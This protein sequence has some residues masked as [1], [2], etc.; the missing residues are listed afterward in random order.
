[1]TPVKLTG[2]ETPTDSYDAVNKQYFDDNF[3]SLNA[4]LDGLDLGTVGGAQNRSMA[5]SNAFKIKKVV[6]WSDG[7][8]GFEISSNDGIYNG[9]RVIICMAEANY[10]GGSVYTIV[11]STT[12]GVSFEKDINVTF[13]TNSDNLD[14]GD[15][16][17]YLI[18]VDKPWLGELE[19][20]YT[21][22]AF[23]DNNIAYARD[24]LAGGRN[25]KALGKYG[26]SL[27]NNTEAGHAALAIGT[28]VKALG[29]NGLATG[30]N[31]KAYGWDSVA[32][33]KD[34]TA[35]GK[36]SMAQNLNTKA[37]GD[38]STALGNNSTAS[39]ES[40]FVTGHGSKATLYAQTVVG[41]FN[42]TDTNAL[43]IIGNGEGDSDRSNAFEVYDDGSISLAGVTITPEQLQGLL[44]LLN[45]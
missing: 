44:A 8:Y 16:Y 29:F 23:G 17:N 40:S 39:G 45:N 9:D 25:T 3:A 5:S 15:I 30:E 26:V 35:S 21:S 32:G 14:F 38:N 22:M 10:I 11:G 34:T 31:T 20:G 43:F 37:I 6:R 7:K 12:I 24:T 18:V 4:A 2:I 33:G 1:M 13:N 41:R 19:V 28:N 27:G 42:D 36:Y